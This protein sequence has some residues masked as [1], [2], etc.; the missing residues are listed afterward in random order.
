MRS[1]TSP[2]RLGVLGILRGSRR[3]S[4][5][6]LKMFSR[7]AIAALKTESHARR[8]WPRYRLATSSPARIAKTTKAN[9]YPGCTLWRSS[10]SSPSPAG[11]LAAASSKQ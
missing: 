2:A 8:R 5:R 10:A 4:R 9:Q 6:T 1:E 3:S 11:H 7:W